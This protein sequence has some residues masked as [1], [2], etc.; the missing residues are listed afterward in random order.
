MF[1]FGNPVVGG[2]TL[3]RAAINSP[4]YVAGQTGWSV[5]ADGSAEFNDVTLRG[6]Q[7]INGTSLFYQGANPAA[8]ELMASISD[9]VGQDPEGNWYL[10]GVCN[11][12][13][14]PFTGIGYICQR[15][16]A[17]ETTWYYSAAMTGAFLPW[18]VRATLFWNE[19]GLII[20]TAGANSPVIIQG[21]SVT[22]NG[23]PA[24]I[25]GGTAASPTKITTDIWHNVTP[26]ANTSGTLRYMLLPDRKMRVECQLTV[27]AAAA[28]GTLTLIT[29]LTPPSAVTRGGVGLFANGT[30]ASI[31]ALL[32]ILEMRW[33]ANAGGTFTVQAFPGGAA[34]TG[35]TELDFTA[36]YSL[37]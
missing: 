16:A 29:G 28:A 1:T 37:V 18:S 22:I 36:E 20:Q 7:T 2:T 32:A 4:D 8:N 10:D 17:G 5:K 19:E 12:G 27:A 24:I 14:D 9:A 33:S 31:A 30:P 35:I 21:Q 11:Y 34:G 6:G 26:P 15:S 25:D 23:G 3:V 13:P